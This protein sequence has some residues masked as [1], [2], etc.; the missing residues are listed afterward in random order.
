MT[1]VRLIGAEDTHAIRHA[2]LR[3]NQ[4]LSACRYPDDDMSE[5]GHFGAFVADELVGVVSIYPQSHADVASDHAWR[6]RG[7]ATLPD[8]RGKGLGMK[9]LQAAETHVAEH[10]G[11][12]VW[13]NARVSA[14]GFYEQAGY[15]KQ[16]EQFEMPNIGPHYVIQKML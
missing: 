15:H 3:P 2:V 10:N 1:I 5:A 4:P 7:M 12:V 13:A 14:L 16:G 8:V 6:I 9:L 11:Q